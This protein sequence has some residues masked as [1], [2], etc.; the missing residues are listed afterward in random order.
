MSSRA[1]RTHSKPKTFRSLTT[2]GAWKH[3]FNSPFKAE[4]YFFNLKQFTSNKWGTP[5]P[6]T[7]RD[8]GARPGAHAGVR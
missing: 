4:V 7:L 5:A 1:A 2:L 8:P 3:G 6:I